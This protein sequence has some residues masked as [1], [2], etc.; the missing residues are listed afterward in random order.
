MQDF[1]IAFDVRCTDPTKS[2][3][4]ETWIDDERFCDLAVS[5]PQHLEFS[6]TLTETPHVL[7]LVLKNKTTE[8][9]Q[10]NDQGQIVQDAMLRIENIKIDDLALDPI[11]S[12]VSKYTHNFNGSGDQVQEKFY[13]HMGCNGAVTVD[14]YVPVYLWFLENL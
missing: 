14:F 8:H 10:V 1:K 3:G 13:G 6:T 4:F 9:T 2:L 5:E 7:K 11:L 12:L